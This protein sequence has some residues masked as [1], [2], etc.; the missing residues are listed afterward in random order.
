MLKLLFA[1][2]TD[3]NSFQTRLFL[4]ESLIHHPRSGK[5]SVTS[6]ETGE[7]L[8]Y[9]DF[10]LQRIDNWRSGILE[11][12]REQLRYHLTSNDHLY[13]MFLAIDNET[14]H[15]ST[16]KISHFAQTRDES[17]D[18]YFE[19]MKEYASYHHCTIEFHGVMNFN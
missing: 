3:I 1:R 11:G 4:K 18:V 14:H 6:L 8:F 13:D 2:G 7:L 9:Y 12:Y 5:V 17:R 19:T 15:V 10:H 16:A